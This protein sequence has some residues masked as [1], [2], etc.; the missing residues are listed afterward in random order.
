MS[1]RCRRCGFLGYLRRI[2]RYGDDICVVDGPLVC[3]V[4]ASPGYLKYTMEKRALRLS[5]AWVSLTKTVQAF[6]DQYIC[7]K[8][9]KEIMGYVL[10][11]IHCNSAIRTFTESW[12]PP[13]GG[14]CWQ[15]TIETAGIAGKGNIENNWAPLWRCPVHI[16]LAMDYASLDSFLA[17]AAAI[18]SKL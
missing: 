16:V 10:R 1:C 2:W 9:T 3:L 14:D 12:G 6:F 18:T 11:K 7:G 4:A 8:T 15:Y 17:L 13:P 5:M